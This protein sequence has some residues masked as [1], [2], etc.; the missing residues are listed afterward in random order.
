[1]FIGYLNMKMNIGRLENLISKFP[2]SIIVATYK[3]NLVGVAELEFDK[4]CPYKE[5]LH[6]N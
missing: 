1:M 4:K 6:P 3:G 2:D 5:L